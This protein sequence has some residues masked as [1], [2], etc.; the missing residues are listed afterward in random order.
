MSLRHQLTACL[1]VLLFNC[2]ALW[3]TGQQVVVSSYYN[4]LDVR[5]EWIELLVVT[6]DT[7]MRG[8]SIRDNNATQDAF[9][10]GITFSTHA[11]WNHLRAGTIIMLYN[12]LNSSSG[13]AYTTDEDKAD[14]YLQVHVQQSAYFSGGSFGA[15][16]TWAGN[17]L[18]FSGT[19]DIVQLLDDNLNHVHAL[20]HKFTVGPDFTALP[21]PKLNHTQALNSG[22]VCMV[23]AGSSLA[24]YG[25][26]L[27]VSGTTFT[28]KST[29]ADVGLPNACA[30]SATANSTYWRSLR[31]PQF[32]LQLVTPSPVVVGT[33]GSISFAWAPALDLVATDG[34]TGYIILRNTVNSFTDPADGTTYTTGSLLG[35]A[36]VLAHINSSGTTTYTD[37]TVMNG[38]EY[39][40]RVYA[41]RYTTD[42][43]NGNSYHPAR[44][45]AYTSTYVSVQTLLLPVELLQLE[46]QLNGDK[47]EI[48]WTTASEENN[49]FFTLEKSADGETFHFLTHVAGCGTCYVENSYWVSDH[50]PVSG[51]CHYRL[52]QTDSNGQRSYCGAC[53]V[54]GKAPEPTLL[55]LGHNRWYA[56]GFAGSRLACSYYDLSGHLLLRFQL[57]NSAPVRLPAIPAACPV[58][59]HLKGLNGELVQRVAGIE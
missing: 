9:Q 33:P 30:A 54:Q 53:T 34:T 48:T 43:P 51:V 11:L 28:A 22:D 38:N 7:D 20:G 16:P 4:A 19:G 18:N 42:Q 10:T 52:W 6:D 32:A 40:Y 21:L 39:Y 24:E 31:E 13:V 44:G 45:R 26:T 36:T 58:L 50:A 23:C 35:S 27:P 47:T 1:F 46:A 17:S 49:A 12:R 2:T 57:E 8:W 59:I 56:V 55:A 25:G 41:Y 37:A 3:A 14:G 5:D 15:A 29:L